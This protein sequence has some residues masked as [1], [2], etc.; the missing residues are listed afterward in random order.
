MKEKD[1]A[2]YYN[3]KETTEVESYADSHYKFGEHAYVA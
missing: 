3:F 1:T 2:K